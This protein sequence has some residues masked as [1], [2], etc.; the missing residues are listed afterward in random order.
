MAWR[1]ALIHKVVDNDIDGSYPP[2][3]NIFDQ[4]LRRM[5]VMLAE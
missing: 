3:L 5:A 2:P 4:I 1:A